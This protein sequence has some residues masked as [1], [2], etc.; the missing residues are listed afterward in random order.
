[1]EE[2]KFLLTKISAQLETMTDLLRGVA[3]SLEHPD[4]LSG[5]VHDVI[6]IREAL[7]EPQ[8]GY[9]C[10][11]RPAGPLARISRALNEEEG[12]HD[13]W[14]REKARLDEVRAGL[15]LR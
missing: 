11:S 12:S 13:R 1:M 14:K 10:D 5:I 7:E 4:E 3:L 9:L 2:I 6:A 8:E 15:R